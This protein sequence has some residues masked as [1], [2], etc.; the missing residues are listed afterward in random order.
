MQHEVLDICRLPYTM[1]NALL[2]RGSGGSHKSSSNLGE[3]LA[4][5]SRGERDIRC[6]HCGNT[7]HIKE[8]CWQLIGYPTWHPRFK[9]QP[10]R[11]TNQA[12]GGNLSRTFKG[13]DQGD[14]KVAAQAE[15]S[16]TKAVTL[17]QQQV[18]QLLKLLPNSS[19]AS[20]EFKDELDNSFAGNVFHSCASFKSEEWILDTGVT[21]H[22]TSACS[23]FTAPQAPKPLRLRQ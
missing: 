18:E 3:A 19:T 10:Q 5:L 22:M 15:S 8:K 6:S 21:D 13:R 11:R 2:S 14:W 20:T 17:T 1:E 7:G 9:R 16:S 12:N 23:I 4:L